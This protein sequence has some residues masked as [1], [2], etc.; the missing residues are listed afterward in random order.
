[1]SSLRQHNSTWGGDGT[2]TRGDMAAGR[3][4]ED[5]D[6][7]GE[8]H[9]EDHVGCRAVAAAVGA[10]GTLPATVAGDLKEWGMGKGVGEG[11]ALLSGSE[12]GH[13]ATSTGLPP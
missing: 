1:M 6:P 12:R 3:V 4:E 8:R 13:Q 7:A 5:G 2:Q 11:E 10:N 9:S